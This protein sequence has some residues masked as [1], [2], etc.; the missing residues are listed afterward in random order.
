MRGRNGRHTPQD[1][2]NQLFLPTGIRRCQ[3]DG[4]NG[5]AHQTWVT[6][7]IGPH[8]SLSPGGSDARFQ[9]RELNFR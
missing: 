9:P 6:V 5:V 3:A 4:F 7:Q 2:L 1:V 8:G